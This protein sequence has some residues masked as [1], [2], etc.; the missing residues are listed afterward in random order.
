MN[1]SKAR[2]SFLIFF[3]ALAAA[4]SAGRQSKPTSSGSSST[5]SGTAP[6]GSTP[7]GT[8]PSGAGGSSGRHIACYKQIGIS[9][10]AMQQRRAIME[11]A[12]E[13]VQNVC[14]DESLTPQQKKEQIHQIHQDAMQQA[15]GVFPA[16]QAAALKK[17]Q[18]E[19]KGAGPAPHAAH[20]GGP[21]G[22][23]LEPEE[24]NAPQ[25]NSPN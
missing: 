17:C 2:L 20:T 22:A 6:S 14:K 10:A 4:A 9:P 1:V 11:A 19:Q 3:V 21:C 5:P 13:K 16:A 18:L 23:S 12:K 7:S 24:N 8:A 25:G 15:E